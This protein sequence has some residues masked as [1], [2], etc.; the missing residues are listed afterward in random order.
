MYFD[1]YRDEV[2][3]RKWYGFWNYGDV[4]HTYDEQRHVWRYD[5]GGFAW[6]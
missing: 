1:F 4:M 5:V 6:D 3:Q 2:E